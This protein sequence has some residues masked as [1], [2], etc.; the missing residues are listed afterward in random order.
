MTKLIGLNNLGNTCYLNSGL[1]LLLQNSDLCNFIITNKKNN[2]ILNELSN[3]INAFQN[4]ENN[5]LSPNY[6]KRIIEEKNN[7]FKGFNQNDA[8]EFIICLLDL[9][10]D[11]L[12]KDNLNLNNIFGIESNIKIK[13]KLKTCLNISQHFENNNYLLLNLKP[14]FKTLTDC[15][16]EYKLR[17]KLMDDNIYFCDKCKDNRIASKRLETSQWSKHLI[18]ILKRFEQNGDRYNKNNNEIDI[19]INWRHNYQLQGFIF[20]SGSINS[21]HYIY[22]GKHQNN[23]YMFNDNFVSQIDI[24]QLNNYKNYAY[25]LY[26]KMNI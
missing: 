8:G 19:P 10:N 5:S 14:N 25:I 26:Y 4:E 7:I 13:C 15:Y 23:W 22:I 2:I 6:I 24:S 17:V 3:F 11:E 20:H 12:I 18:I 16:R 1:Q 21:G 9:I